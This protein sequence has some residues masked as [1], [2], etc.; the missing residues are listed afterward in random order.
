M[1]DAHETSLA[2]EHGS[3]RLQETVL[4]TLS[5]GVHSLVNG[6]LYDVDVYLVCHFTLR[7]H[8]YQM[9][10]RSLPSSVGL[11]FVGVIVVI[12]VVANDA[13]RC[14]FDPNIGR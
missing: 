11:V 3:D 6:N 13:N 7:P 1:N 4:P 9:I 14:V 5:E 12:V 8:R 2:T 10:R